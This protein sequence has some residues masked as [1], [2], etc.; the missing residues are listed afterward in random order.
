VSTRT[1]PYEFSTWYKRVPY[2]HAPRGARLQRER[3]HLHPHRTLQGQSLVHSKGTPTRL[4]RGTEHRCG[5]RLQRE[6]RHLHMHCALIRLV[7]STEQYYFAHG[8]HL[9]RLVFGTERCHLH[10]HRILQGQSVVWSKEISFFLFFCFCFFFV[11]CP[12]P[13]LLPGLVFVSVQDSTGI[14][15]D[16]DSLAALLSLELRADRPHPS[17][18]R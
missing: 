2:P 5:A 1:A 4:V 17:L 10:P 16:N 3:C 13:S 18:G 7:L 12:F 6:R 11:H 8:L 14:F 9:T 15:W